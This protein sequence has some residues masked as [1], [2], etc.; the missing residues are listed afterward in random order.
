MYKELLPTDET[1][2]HAGGHP[3]VTDAWV[4]FTRPTAMN[5]LFEN[6][7]HFETSS[8]RA[9]PF[10][11]AHWFCIASN[12]P[13]TFQAVQFSRSLQPWRFQSRS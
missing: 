1:V 2:P 7:E 3:V 13:L 9:A 6:L 11:E 8:M 12:E 4:F 10:Q 5:Y